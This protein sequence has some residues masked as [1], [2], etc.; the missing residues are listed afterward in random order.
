MQIFLKIVFHASK[1]ESICSLPHDPHCYMYSDVLTLTVTGVRR[2]LAQL[3]SAGAWATGGLRVQ[4]WNNH[5][6]RALRGSVHTAEKREEPRHR[7]EY[8]PSLLK[9]TCWYLLG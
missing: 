2:A 1:V 5:A 9:N 8:I 7:C 3:A 4:G 6:A